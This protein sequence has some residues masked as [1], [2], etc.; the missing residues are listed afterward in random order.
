MHTPATKRKK[1]KIRQNVGNKTL[2]T[3]AEIPAENYFQINFS[4]QLSLKM[5]A[6]YNIII[7][8]SK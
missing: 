7:I 3:K 5:Q 1:Q 4:M 2:E 8:L 6:I